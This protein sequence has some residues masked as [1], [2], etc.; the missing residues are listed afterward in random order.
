MEEL[1]L[2]VGI[3]DLSHFT[4]LTTSVGEEEAIDYLQDA[5]KAAGDMILKHNGQ[6]R[7]YIGDAILFTFLDPVSAIQAARKITSCYHREVN[8]NLVRFHVAIATGNV[9]V[10]KIGHPS[11]LIEDV[12]GEVVN[13]AIRLMNEAHENDFGIA[14][15]DET[16]KY[17]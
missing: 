4:E 2:S 8:T 6:I 12:M 9:L 10:G 7:K 16:K 1:Y 13:R 11:F 5:F 14:L 15:C 17:A 3:A